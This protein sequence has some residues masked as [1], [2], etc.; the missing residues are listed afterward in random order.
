M[1]QVVKIILFVL[2][3][4]GIAG[5]AFAQSPDKA[6]ADAL[7]ALYASTP[8]AR[9]LGENAKG[10]LVFPNI[11]KAAAL[12]GGQ[13]GK[14]VMV[15]NGKVAGHYRADG[16]LVGLEAGAQSFSYVVF[17]MSD[18]ALQ[19]LHESKGFEV[20]T[21]PNIV[22]ANDGVAKNISTTTAQD[23]VYSYVFGQKGLMAGVSVQG[24]KITQL[25]H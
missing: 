6:A 20:G 5:A 10:I 18:K 11:R 13:S 24:L 12:V 22:I 16:V 25:G 14:G 4:L 1:K 2:A 7:A 23:D 9:A 19:N 21:E 8:A 17:F 15:A 3:S